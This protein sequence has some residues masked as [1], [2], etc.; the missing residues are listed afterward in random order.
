MAYFPTFVGQ[1]VLIETIFRLNGVPQDPNIVTLTASSPSGVVSTITYPAATYTRRSTGAYEGS[2]LVNE[3]GQWAFRAEGVGIVD[4]VN[5]Y[6][7]DVQPS[8]IPTH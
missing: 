5:E 4:A 2:V 1:R 7:V 6:I 3:P 8:F